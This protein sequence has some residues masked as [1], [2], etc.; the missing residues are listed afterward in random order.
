MET[1]PEP[2]RRTL[3]APGGV[4][5]GLDPLLAPTRD[6]LLGRRPHR[7]PRWKR[8]LKPGAAAPAPSSEW[9]RLEA[10]EQAQ[11][12]GRRTPGT[13]H[14]LLALLAV[15]EVLSHQAQPQPQPDVDDTGGELLARLGLDYADA[16]AALSAGTIAL[17]ADPRSVEA[18]LAGAAPGPLVRALLDEDTRARRLVEALGGGG[19]LGTLG[20]GERAHPAER[21]GGPGHRPE[22]Q[23]VV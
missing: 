14:V 19:G 21:Q 15:H 23:R 13:E 1:M 10:D 16:H 2:D 17:P 11:R 9:I 18:Y 5:P 6:T 12:L 20:D 8:L 7:L 3:G 22:G 4:P